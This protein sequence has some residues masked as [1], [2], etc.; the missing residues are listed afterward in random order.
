MEDN[1]KEINKN[2]ETFL[3]EKYSENPE[4][5]IIKINQIDGMT[6]QNYQIIYNN[7]NEPKKINEVLYRKYGNI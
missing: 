4:D 1:N 3:K 7:K 5:M 6:N 2:F